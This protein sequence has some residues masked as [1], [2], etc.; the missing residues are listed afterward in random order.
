MNRV[1]KLISLVDSNIQFAINIQLHFHLS[2]GHLEFVVHTLC[3]HI[4]P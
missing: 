4:F 2:M 1:Q 3:V